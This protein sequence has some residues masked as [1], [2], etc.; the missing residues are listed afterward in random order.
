MQN[1]ITYSQCGAEEKPFEHQ[2]TLEMYGRI[3]SQELPIYGIKTLAL[4]DGT[5]DLHGM[6]SLL[7]NTAYLNILQHASLGLAGGESY[8]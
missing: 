3:N 2:F 8:R 6:Y 1:K 5:L 4:R 7:L